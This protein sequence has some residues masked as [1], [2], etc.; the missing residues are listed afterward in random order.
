M[1]NNFWWLFAAYS[2]IWVAILGFVVRLL[3]RQ[4]ELRKDLNRLE[5]EIGR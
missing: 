2:V 4:S 1:P 5:S 3:S